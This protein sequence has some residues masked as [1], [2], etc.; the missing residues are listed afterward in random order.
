MFFLLC[1]SGVREAYVCFSA[2]VCLCMTIDVALCLR[3]WLF[4]GVLSL[5]I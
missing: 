3:K 5:L 1:V 2:R 4:C